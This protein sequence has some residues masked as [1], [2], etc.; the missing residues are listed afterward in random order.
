M[1]PLALLLMLHTH[2]STDSNKLSGIALYYGD[3]TYK[4]LHCMYALDVGKEPMN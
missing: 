2:N 3:T 4:V 1:L